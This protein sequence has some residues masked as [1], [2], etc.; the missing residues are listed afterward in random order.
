MPSCLQPYGLPDLRQSVPFFIDYRIPM[1][2]P[3]IDEPGWFTSAFESEIS[4]VFTIYIKKNLHNWVWS[5]A[6][7]FFFNATVKHSIIVKILVHS[8]N[9]K[10]TLAC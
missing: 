4:K 7:K 2:I 9:C 5:G 3:L 1:R 6:H 8:I 10:L